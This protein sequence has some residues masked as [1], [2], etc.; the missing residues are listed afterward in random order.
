[1][2]ATQ[3]SILTDSNGLSLEAYYQFQSEAVKVDPSGTYFGSDFIGEGSA[4]IIAGGAFDYETQGGN[5]C[6]LSAQSSLLCTADALAT[7]RARSTS[8]LGQLSTA[9]GELLSNTN[10][11]TL[12]RLQFANTTMGS[13][14]GDNDLGSDLVDNTILT[15]G[16]AALGIAAGS[17]TAASTETGAGTEIFFS[18]GNAGFSSSLAALAAQNVYGDTQRAG[19]EIFK[20]RSAT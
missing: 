16:A 20:R 7:S 8:L 13:A 4:S 1:M 11:I 15:A 10:G 19:V 2:P 6:N 14:S 3:L 18:A 5:T 17:N 12:A 9:Y